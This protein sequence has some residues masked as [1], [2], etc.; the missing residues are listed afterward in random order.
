MKIRHKNSIPSVSAMSRA[1]PLPLTKSC[2]FAKICDYETCISTYFIQNER[3]KPLFEKLTL[4]RHFDINGVNG[5]D[6][7]RKESL[8]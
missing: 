3:G 6:G 2:F 4:I 5:L 1:S 8:I 7:M